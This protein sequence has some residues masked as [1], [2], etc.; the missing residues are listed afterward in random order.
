V[1]LNRAAFADPCDARS[2]R[3]PCGVF[4]SLGSFVIDNPG[5]VF[6]DLSVFKNFK[7]TERTTLQFRSEFFNIFNHTNFG[8][9]TASLTSA[10]FGQVTSSGRARELQFAAKLIW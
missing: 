3:R 7:L 9:P 1:Y 2:L 8:S 10:T 5:S 4:G 6:Y